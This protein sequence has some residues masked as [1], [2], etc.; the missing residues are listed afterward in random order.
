MEQRF[1]PP[2]RCLLLFMMVVLQRSVRKGKDT[3]VGF[4]DLLRRYDE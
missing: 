3:N 1:I 2:Q 4:V